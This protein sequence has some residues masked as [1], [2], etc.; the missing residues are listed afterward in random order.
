M[1]DRGKRIDRRQ[2]LALGATAGTAVAAGIV[3][4]HDG[5]LGGPSETITR[6][7]P[8]QDGMAD[9]PDD[10]VKADLSFL[11]AAEMGFVAAAADRLIPPDET[12]PSAS[13]AGVPTFI[14]R[15]LAGGYGQGHHFYLGGPWP[16][17]TPTQGYQSRYA[18]AQFY[19]AAIAAIEK[20]VGDNNSGKAFKNLDPDQQDALLKN[21]EGGK[22]DLGAIDGKEFFTVFLQNVKEGYFSDP[23]YGGNRDMAAWKM[24]GFPGAH[25][26][27]TDWVSRHGQPVPI[28]LVSLVGR[29][30]WQKA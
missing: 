23:I 24:I 5:M 14:D 15:Q 6:T 30:G 16:K 25:Y 22:V 27:Y 11:N 10:G 29:P 3:S 17:G 19:R 8:W 28:K 26:D 18:P 7:L 4:A 12:G 20:H 2:L 13:E 9:A 1:T 21:L